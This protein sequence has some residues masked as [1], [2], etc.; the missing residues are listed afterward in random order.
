MKK[1]II[2]SICTFTFASTSA[3]ADHIVV[4]GDVSG[5]WSSDTVLVAGEIS[6]PTD[7]TLL[8]EPGVRV[9]FQVYCKFIV[10]T[11]ATL[12]AIG[13]AQDSIRF[14]EAYTDTGW[15]AIRF[16]SAFSAFSNS[17]VSFCRLSHG[18]VYGFGADAEGG[19]IYCS[20]S[21]P[22][23][24]HCLFD[25]CHSTW[26]G[27]IACCNNSA[28]TISYNTITGCGDEGYGHGGAI[29]CVIGSEPLISHNT[30]TENWT[31]G[32]SSGGGISCYNSNAIIEE[33][34]IEDNMSGIGMAI[35][36]GYSNPLIHKNIITLSDW[37]GESGISCWQSS[38]TISNN[39][40][41][42]N[43]VWGG[44]GIY[45]YGNSDPTIINN[46]ISNCHGYLGE[47]LP[48]ATVPAHKS[49]IRSS[50][51]TAPTKAAVASLVQIVPTPR[52]SVASSGRTNWNRSPARPPRSRRWNTATCR[53]AGRASAISTQ[54]PCSSPAP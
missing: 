6:I 4:S 29:Y 16:N 47:A 53:T 35:D 32:L 8:I 22:E 28:P 9:L 49:S 52:S 19:A 36:L 21:H 51:T 13:T 38:P 27:A 3:Q 5:T 25:D 46:V 2:I 30:I 39:I 14:D 20:N 31:C 7:G 34:L 17:C 43:P 45:C 41:T 37:G 15:N 23:I 24:S 54:T 48:A 26:G 33:N 42:G 12:L 10:D 18:K 40:I 11:N 1:V 50:R 44:P